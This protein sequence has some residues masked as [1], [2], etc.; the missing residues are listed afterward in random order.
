M[1]KTW[2]TL[3]GVGTVVM[4]SGL[5]FLPAALTPAVIDDAMLASGLAVFSTGIMLIACSFYFKTR[6]LHKA[7]AADPN[8]ALI[9]NTR[10]R[11]GSCDSCRGGAPLIYCTMHRLNLCGTCLGQHYEARGCV[12]VPAV[13]KPAGR[14][15]RA[16]AAARS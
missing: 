11:K 9:L 4:F 10:K 14:T 12:Y 15:A 3:I 8:L 7:I 13:R 2:N 1:Q 6:A 5:L 16:S